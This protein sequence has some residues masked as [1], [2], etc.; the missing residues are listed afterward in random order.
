MVPVGRRSPEGTERRTAPA[1]KF[2][3][4]QSAVPTTDMRRSMEF[5]PRH[6]RF[7]VT[8]SSINGVGIVSV[9]N[10]ATSSHVWSYLDF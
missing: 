10:L 8:R 2:L 3:A 6:C 7:H 5:I 1:L 9:G 4:Q